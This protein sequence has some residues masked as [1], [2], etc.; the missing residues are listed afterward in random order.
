MYGWY[1]IKW[2]WYCISII[3]VMHPEISSRKFPFRIS[4]FLDP[5]KS[6]GH[7]RYKKIHHNENSQKLRKSQDNINNYYKKQ[8]EKL[9]LT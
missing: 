1:D 2:D 7:Q 5:R 4:I 3:I 6:V 8:D 9:M